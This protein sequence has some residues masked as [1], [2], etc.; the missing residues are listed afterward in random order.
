MWLVKSNCQQQIRA[1]KTYNIRFCFAVQIQTQ[2]R[3]LRLRYA[4]D[5]PSRRYTPATNKSDIWRTSHQTDECGTRPFLDGSGRRAVA[6]TCPAVPKMHLALSAFRC[7]AMNLTPPRRVKT[8]GGTAPLREL[9]SHIYRHT[10]IHMSISKVNFYPVY[11][12]QLWTHWFNRLSQHVHA[13]TG[14]QILFYWTGHSC[15]FLHT[16]SRT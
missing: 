8:W 7:H 9:K 14:E 1:H 12:S 4:A 11:F 6:Q 3:H 10:C 2:E 5:R 15:V 13:H 16:H